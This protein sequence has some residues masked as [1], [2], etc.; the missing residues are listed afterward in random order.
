MA[1]RYVPSSLQGA[2]PEALT[3]RVEEALGRRWLAWSKPSTGLS[4]AHRFLVELDDR[5]SVFVKG[6]TTAQTAVWLRNEREAIA[7][8][9]TF[10]PKEIAWIDDGDDAPILV[11][12]ALVEAYWPVRGC[13][14][15]WRPGDLERV[16]SAIKA[17]S[18][19]KPSLARPADPNRPAR[20]GR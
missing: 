11:V 4:A 14:T 17:L 20:D 13:G 8:A 7:A 3:A 16:V 2:P 15:Q 18:E 12:E 19:L 10:A 6:A 1:D 5:A 9:P